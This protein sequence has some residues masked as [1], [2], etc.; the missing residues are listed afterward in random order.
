MCDMLGVFCGGVI[1][2]F[3][4]DGLWLLWLYV[5]IGDMFLVGVYVN[6]VWVR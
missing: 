6:V 3:F 1:I 2:V 4:W 5:M